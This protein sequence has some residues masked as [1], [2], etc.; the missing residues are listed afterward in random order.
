[1][2]F[3]KRRHERRDTITTIEYVV[4]P[5]TTDDAFDGVIVNVSKSGFCLLTANPLSKGEKITI[6]NKIHVD[7]QTATVCWSDKYNN[8]YKAGLEFV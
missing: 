6:K 3:D 8:L 2:S 4:D 1:M 5:L 7:S